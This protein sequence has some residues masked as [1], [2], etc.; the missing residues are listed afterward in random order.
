LLV[1]SLLGY[2]ARKLD[3]RSWRLSNLVSFD[4]DHDTRSNTKNLEP[5]VSIIIP[6]RDKP[7]LLRACIESIGANTN[8]SNYELLIVDNSSIEPETKDLLAQYESEGVSIL[9]YPGVFNYSAICNF[10]ATKATGEYLCFLNNDTEA[11]SKNWLSSMVEHAS[12]GSSGLVGAVLSY[13]NGSIQHTGIALGYTG[14]AGHPYRGESKDECVPESCFQ[15]SAVTFACAMI[16]T[17]KF[18]EIGALDEKFPSGFNDVDISEL[19]HRE[20]QTRPKSLSI[21][22]FSRAVTDVIGILRKHRARIRDPFF[23]VGTYPR[24]HEEPSREAGPGLTKGQTEE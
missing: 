24:T 6:T 5:K 19:I 17:R 18:W 1:S 20:A 10:A 13:P 16:A 11:V 2:L 4:N 23:A 14:I 22:G 7:K 12:L 21:S 9:K 3:T 8:Y 15:V